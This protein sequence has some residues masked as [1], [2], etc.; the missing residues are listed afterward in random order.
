MLGQII[1]A[2]SCVVD[3][4]PQRSSCAAEMLR[5]QVCNGSD[6]TIAQDV[7]KTTFY[8][9]N[10]CVV[11]SLSAH[12]LGCPYWETEL[13]HSRSPSSRQRTTRSRFKLLFISSQPAATPIGTIGRDSDFCSVV[14]P[15]A[16]AIST[17]QFEFEMGRR[18]TRRGFALNL[19]RQISHR[20]SV[21]ISYLVI[22][23]F[24]IPTSPLAAFSL[25]YTHQSA[26]YPIEF[27]IPWLHCPNLYCRVRLIVCAITKTCA[28]DRDGATA[29]CHDP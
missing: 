27:Q 9:S 25:Q 18:K 11:M 29:S 6:F 15:D 19:A 2:P 20:G 14:W 26:L 10:C 22:S 3:G 21:H 17:F 24:I 28:L 4:Q 1:E 8:V 23:Y 7:P 12:T 5:G 13:V 16:L